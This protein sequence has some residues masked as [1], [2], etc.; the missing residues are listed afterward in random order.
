MKKF[1]LTLAAILIFIHFSKGQNTFPSSGNVGIGTTSPQ[2]PLHVLNNGPSVVT[3]QS[4]AGDNTNTELDLV[5]GSTNTGWAIGTNKSSVSGA[6]DNLFF[7]KLFGTAGT[8]MVINDQGNVGI[9]TTNPMEKL[10]INGNIIN[11]NG[12]WYSSRTTSGTSVQMLGIGS[13]NNI[14]IGDLF[15]RIPS[16]NL[17]LRTNGADRMVISGSGNIG[18]GTDSPHSLLSLQGDNQAISVAQSNFNYNG[19]PIGAELGAWGGNYTNAA[20]IKFHRW[21]GTATNYGTAYIGQEFNGGYGIAF[22]TDDLATLGDATTTRMFITNVGNVGIGTVS[23]DQKLT[24]NGTIHS[25]EIK[26]DTSIPVPDYVFDS[27]YKLTDLLSLQDYL[28]KYH[29]LPE[30]PSAS[31]IQKEGLKL[32]EMNTLLLKKVEELTLYLIE[33]DKQ[34]KDQNEVNQNLQTKVN[35]QQKDIDDLKLKLNTLLQ[36]LNPYK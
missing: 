17:V 36:T 15:G 31:Q 13:S 12:Q 19:N 22:K 6:A 23:P 18:L 14:Y 34:I 32:G 28:N 21:T 33:K 16:N 20:G 25:S 27:T 29:H 4:T 10:D 35:Q 11:T 1:N 7:Y 8:K 9:A 5:G 2:A 30:I 24:V 26:V 3:I